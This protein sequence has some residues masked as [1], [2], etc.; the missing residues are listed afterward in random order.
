MSLILTLTLNN[1]IN[2]NILKGERC[3]CGQSKMETYQLKKEQTVGTGQS[4]SISN[5]GVAANRCLLRDIPWDILL[6]SRWSIQVWAQFVDT[7]LLAVLFKLQRVWLSCSTLGIGGECC[8]MPVAR[9]H[10]RTS[11]RLVES[12]N[13]T[14]STPNWCDSHRLLWFCRKKNLIAVWC[15]RKLQCTF[16]EYLPK[17]DITPLWFNAETGTALFSMIQ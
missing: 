10:R 9:C 6:Q 5:Y 12:W 11:C 17:P 14:T 15:E 3:S 16:E 13:T 4:I 7:S 2:Q 1:L 8:S